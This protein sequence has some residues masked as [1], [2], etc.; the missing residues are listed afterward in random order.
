MQVLGCKYIRKHL[1]AQ[2]F[3]I[4]ICGPCEDFPKS[5][6]L[7]NFCVPLSGVQHYRPQDIVRIL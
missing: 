7:E 2:I 1:L 4:K 6:P 3:F 5:L